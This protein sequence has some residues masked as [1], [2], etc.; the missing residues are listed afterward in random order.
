MCER[1]TFI[2]HLCVSPA[3]FVDEPVQASLDLVVGQE[4]HVTGVCDGQ[5]VPVP[6]KG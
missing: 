3:R 2:M 1:Q 4:G 5:A 6:Q